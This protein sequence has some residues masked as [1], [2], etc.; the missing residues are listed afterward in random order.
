VEEAL[1]ASKEE[2]I[3]IQN[4]KLYVDRRKARPKP[5]NQWRPNMARAETRPRVSP[6]AK[7]SPAKGQSKGQEMRRTKTVR[8]K[9]KG[10]HKTKSKI[11]G[12]KPSKKNTLPKGFAGMSGVVA[13]YSRVDDGLG[14]FTQVKRN[15]KKTGSKKKVKGRKAR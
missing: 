13:G 5:R 15:K 7:K 10:K 1:R 2:G 12:G 3:F 4:Q 8:D 11:S 6:I 14:E 9:T